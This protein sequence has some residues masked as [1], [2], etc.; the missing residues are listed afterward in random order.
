M[1]EEIGPA[2][3]DEIAARLTILEFALEVLFAR[4]LA[5]LSEEL[6]EQTKGAFLEVMTRTDAVSDHDKSIQKRAEAIGMKFV[7][8][9]SE[10]ER[11]MRMK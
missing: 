7:S 9:V 11:S 5:K 3:L 1:K 8:K 10:R 2:E 6:S 4:D